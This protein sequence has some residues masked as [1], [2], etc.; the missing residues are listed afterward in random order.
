VAVQFNN[1]NN[2][3]ETVVTREDTENGAREYKAPEKKAVPWWILPL[4]LIPLLLLLFNRNDNST[5]RASSAVSQPAPV[6]SVAVVPTPTPVPSGMAVAD[7]M[8]AAQ[9][10]NANGTDPDPA[11]AAA[12]QGGTTPTMSGSPESASSLS[13]TEPSGGM[14]EDLKVYKGKDIAVAQRG[15]ASNEG[16]LLSDVVTFATASDKSAL[17]GRKVKLTNVPVVSVI[18]SRAFYVGP[19]S[20]QQMFVLLDPKMQPTAK[21]NITISQGK[22]VSLVGYVK[23]LPQVSELQGQYQ[24]G[25]KQYG[26]VQNEGAYLHATIAQEK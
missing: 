19:S 26:M 3:P 7:G 21:S 9:Q 24:I 25:Q 15:R 14:G 17:I 11:V 23:A 8:D 12:E 16:E 10:A 6:G 13:G 1:K 20:S 18:N 2:K 22:T 5:D 4:A